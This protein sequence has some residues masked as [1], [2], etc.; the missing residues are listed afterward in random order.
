[1]ILIG[2]CLAML[3]NLNRI[4][5]VT[6]FDIGKAWYNHFSEESFKK[7]V[8]LGIRLYFNVLVP[9][10]QFILRIDFAR[11]LDGDDK[12]SRIWIGINHA[13]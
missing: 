11:P 8:G 13:F 12:D 2:Q 4:Q 9:I 10:E 1:M 5:G 7:D 6:F 3:F